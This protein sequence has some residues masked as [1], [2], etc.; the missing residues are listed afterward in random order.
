MGI[1][2]LRA[3]TIFLGLMIVGH[4]S[5]ASGRERPQSP[6]GLARELSEKLQTCP[7]D[8]REDLLIEILDHWLGPDGKPM[9]PVML[10]MLDDK[11][12]PPKPARPPFPFRDQGLFRV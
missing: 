1:A 7:R 2:S 6:S 11:T 12:P 4:A 5:F 9:I 8:E 3:S 10:G